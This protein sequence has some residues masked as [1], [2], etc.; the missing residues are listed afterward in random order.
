MADYSESSAG[1]LIARIDRA[2]AFSDKRFAVVHDGGVNLL[3]IFESGNVRVSNAIQ[4]DTQI[5]INNTN[6]GTDVAVFQSSGVSVAAITKSGL[7]VFDQGGM[8]M[9][10]IAGPLPASAVDGEIVLQK[11][12]GGFL[13]MYAWYGGTWRNV[14]P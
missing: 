1:S 11:K 2:N 12:K 9:R 6:T 13:H 5:Q 10:V 7:G 4:R 14:E 3:E 8:R